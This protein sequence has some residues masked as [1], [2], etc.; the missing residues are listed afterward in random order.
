MFILILNDLEFSDDEFKDI[1]DDNLEYYLRRN[2]NVIK[3]SLFTL[4]EYSGDETESENENS[5]ER[6]NLNSKNNV[7]N[8]SNFMSYSN[9]SETINNNSVND[10]NCSSSDSNDKKEHLSAHKQPP[11]DLRKEHFNVVNIMEESLKQT[12]SQDTLNEEE[13]KEDKEIK[14][15]EEEID[16]ILSC[17]P[18]EVES[19]ANEAKNHKELGN[20]FFK[21]KDYKKALE[22]YQKAVD[23]CPHNH[24]E[25]LAIYYNNMAACYV[26][27]GTNEQVATYCT[28]A[29]DCNPNYVKALVRR[30]YANEKIG[31]SFAISQAIEDH[32][33]V[34]ELD[35]DNNNASH[36]ALRRLEVMLKAQQEKEKEEMLAK[37]KDV[38]NKLLGKLGLSLDNFNLQP[39]ANGGYSINM[40]K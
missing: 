17:T 26:Y 16:K 22:E 27:I 19:L 28:R 36:K 12:D 25:D 24:K 1:E 4:P 39:N 38:G 34:L 23:I 11:I 37:M 31:K 7:N 8:N 40:N 15:L 30:A 32:K 6:T 20:Q 13:S 3:K 14:Q 33:K 10:T 21:D 35:P 2:P 5:N 29:I 18:E 9:S